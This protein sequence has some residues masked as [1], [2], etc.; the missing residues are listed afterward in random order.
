MAK[1]KKQEQNVKAK[2]RGR[3]NPDKTAIKMEIEAADLE[4]KIEVA[5]A[6][7]TNKD[8]P[9]RAWPFPTAQSMHVT[10]GT[11]VVAKATGE[12]L[13]HVRVIRRQDL[14]SQGEVLVGEH[15]HERSMIMPSNLDPEQIR[16]GNVPRFEIGAEVEVKRTEVRGSIHSTGFG[17]SK[18]L[19]PWYM[20]VSGDG[21]T[22]TYTHKELQFIAIPEN[23]WRRKFGD[24]P[25][26][27]AFD[28]EGRTYLKV[29]NSTAVDCEV[30][31]ILPRP[32]GVEVKAAVYDGDMSSARKTRFRKNEIVRILG[33]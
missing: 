16:W 15:W 22:K 31:I 23:A 4:Q 30:R 20:V 17:R 21:S 32:C 18:D 9:A 12:Y 13:G 11:E 6:A 24:I 28:F 8:E 5:Q 26:F 33:R 1:Q 10:V 27:A 29:G 2:P 14:E 3:T 7:D 19:E 25:F